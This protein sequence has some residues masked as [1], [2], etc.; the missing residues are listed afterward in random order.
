LTRQVLSSEY[1]FVLTSAPA[2]VSANSRLRL[3]TTNGRQSGDTDEDDE[4]DT[5]DEDSPF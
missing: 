1:R 5:D 2:C 4:D 3:P